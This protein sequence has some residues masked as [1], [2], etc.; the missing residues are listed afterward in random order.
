MAALYATVRAD[1]DLLDSRVR[2]RTEALALS[3]GRL[4]SLLSLSADWIWEQD[5]EL[6]FSY[7][8]DGIEAATGIAPTWLIGKQRMSSDAFDAPAERGCLVEPFVQ[9]TAEVGGEGRAHVGAGLGLP[10]EGLADVGPASK[11]HRAL[12]VL[13]ALSLRLRPRANQSRSARSSRAA[14][15]PRRSPPAGSASM[16]S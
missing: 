1:R 11:T 3:E 9:Y 10:L 16:P 13:R 14:P 5:A 6:R 7:F 15:S 4:S 2:E 12:R 8:S